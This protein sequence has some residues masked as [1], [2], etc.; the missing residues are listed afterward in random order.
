LCSP[1][2]NV[3][4]ILSSRRQLEKEAKLLQRSAV[5]DSAVA[6]ELEELEAEVARLK[7]GSFPLRL[8]RCRVVRGPVGLCCAIWRAAAGCRGGCECTQ[9]SGLQAGA[10][11]LEPGGEEGRDPPLLSLLLW[12]G[13]AAA[14]STRI[15][16]G[17]CLCTRCAAHTRTFAPLRAS[18]A[19][20]R[21]GMHGLGPCAHLS[22]T[23]IILLL[24]TFASCVCQAEAVDMCAALESDIK[25]SDRTQSLQVMGRAAR[26][27][28]CVFASG[29]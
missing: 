16:L 17:T 20:P 9:L 5:L 4:F 26:A 1:Y 2:L 6:A 25:E 10:E 29:L 22:S 18:A 13:R 19:R 21:C 3:C 11:E 27:R 12:L 23:E 28:A 15:G 7:V 8:G 24:H 14:P